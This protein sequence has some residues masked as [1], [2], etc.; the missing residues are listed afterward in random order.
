MWH[1]WNGYVIIHIEGLCAARFLKRI[2]DAG[3]R[4]SNVRKAGDAEYLL[5]IPAKRF[6]ELRK[7]RRGLPLRIRITER[8]GMPFYLRKLRRRPVLWIGTVVL[9]IG[10][11]FL[12]T[13]VWIIRIPETKRVDPEEITALLRERGIYP[14]ARPE[15]P[16]LITAANDLS[17][18]IREAAWIGLDREG[19]LLTV[20]VVESLPE[21]A[22]RTDRVPSD[23]VAERDGVVTQLQVMRGQARVK[24]GDRVKAGDV[25]ISGVVFYKDSSYET[26]ADGTV[27]AAVEYR[28]ERELSDRIT[29]AYETDRTETVSSFR[30]WNHTV[31]CTKPSFEHYRL[32]GHET[33]AANGLLPVAIGTQT[34]REIGFRERMLSEEESEQYALTEAREQALKAVPRDASVINTYGTIRTKQGKKIAVVIVTAEEIIGKTEEKPHD[35]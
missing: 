11:L 33:V 34:A 20:N 2:A 7:L 10:I 25:L 4:V 8:G 21:S 29:E 35:G 30:I 1:F 3:I 6:F 5:T 24:V 19:V 9:F 18:Q 12:S 17:A 14:G 26:A 28:S 16:I 15:G 13:R 22:K 32:I 27:Y 23:I 31:F